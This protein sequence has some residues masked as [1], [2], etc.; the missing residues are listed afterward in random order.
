MSDS[1]DQLDGKSTGGFLDGEDNSGGDLSSALDDLLKEFESYQSDPEPIPTEEEISAMEKEE[2]AAGSSSLAPKREDAPPSV[3]G[4][5]DVHASE[6]D[7]SDHGPADSDE[8]YDPGQVLKGLSSHYSPETTPHSMPR[9]QVGMV[10]R[11]TITLNNSERFSWK[12]LV[13]ESFFGLASLV[14]FVLSPRIW[15][16]RVRN[17]DEWQPLHR[18][19][20]PARVNFPQAI[21]IYARHPLRTIHSIGLARPESSKDAN[22]LVDV[23]SNAQIGWE[24]TEDYDPIRVRTSPTGRQSHILTG[25]TWAAI[26]HYQSQGET[27]VGRRIYS[28]IENIAD[29]HPHIFL[30]DGM[31]DW[32]SDEELTSFIE[33]D[34]WFALAQVKAIRPDRLSIYSTAAALVFG[35]ILAGHSLAQNFSASQEFKRLVDEF[36]NLPGITVVRAHQRGQSLKVNLLADPLSQNPTASIKHLG[37]ENRVELHV[38]PYCSLDPEIV[39][40]RA[41][42]NL[43]PPPTATLSLA[44]NRLVAIGSAPASWIENATQVARLI[45]GI[46][47]IDF[48]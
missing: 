36:E 29:Q 24:E 15:G 1:Q 20:R 6:G 18:I 4:T 48:F 3:P 13:V 16:K 11:A 39:I 7:D 22:W 26:C 5:S 42:K 47:E 37:L 27:K 23:E 41:W 12:S 10:S 32:A 43:S 45:P 14:E 31:T 9:G 30:P 19:I 40:R 28:I 33:L 17:I 21:R 25:D 35:A 2:A 44:G 8:D 38:E 46:E 34:E